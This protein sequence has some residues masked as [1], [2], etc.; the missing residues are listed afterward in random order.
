MLIKSL[1]EYYDIKMTEEQNKIPRGYSESEVSFEILLDENGNITDILDIR[2]EVITKL[3]NDK[4]KTELKPVI[5]NLPVR[6]QKPGI[7]SNIIEHRPTY[8]FGLNLNKD[9]FS[10]EDRT[11]KAKKSHLAFKELNSDFFDGLESPVCQ[12]YRNFI[13]NWNPE[14]QT[15][16]PHLLNI[17][18]DYNK[19]FC[20]GLDGHPDIRLQEDKEFLQKYNKYLNEKEMQADENAEI[21]SICPITGELEPTARI[22]SKISFPGGQTSGSVLIGMKED[23]YCSYNKIQSYNSNISKTAMEK[24]TK[25]F[26]KLLKDKTHRFIIDDMVVIYFGMKKDDSK[27]CDILSMLSGSMPDINS[28]LNEVMSNLKNGMPV[29]YSTLKIDPKA[30]F[31]IAGLTPNASRICQ[32]FI[33]RNKFGKIMENILLH[34]KDMSIVNGLD[35]VYFNQIKKELLS[36][37]STNAKVSPPLISEIFLAAFN[38]TNYPRALLETVIR[39]VKTDSDGE[40]QHFIKFNSIRVGIIKACINRSARLLNKKEELTVALDKTN[41]NQAYLC[42]RYFAVLE[43]I[44]Q[45]AADGKLNTTITDSYFSS[46]AAKPAT[47]FTKLSQLSVHHLKKI[48]SKNEGRYINL[49]KLINEIMEK[50]EG[51]FPE[52]LSLKE[53]G[54]FIV[55]YYQQ[56]QELFKKSE[57]EN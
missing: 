28:V 7:D 53:Q 29:N 42:G 25:A 57:K 44:Q 30:D 40:N 16:N 5:V 36:P 19:S 37:K 1:C 15:E 45:E 54:K 20:F 34:Q 14:E 2:K 23:A 39:R 55:G 10:A 22:H 47:I 31:Y 43:K 21:K 46:A 50:L 56:N 13:E 4:T 8:I 18:K 33:I 6:T 35:F 32:K 12:A 49:K 3:K 27:E 51:E 24:Y 41:T 26:N 52:T 17:K 9:E 11:N 38:G 48:S